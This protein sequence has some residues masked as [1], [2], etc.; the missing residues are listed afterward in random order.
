MKNRIH[1]LLFISLSLI[2]V[3]CSNDEK[4]PLQGKVQFA[5]SIATKSS[6]GGR[7]LTQSFPDGAYIALSIETASGASV[8]SLKRVELL[9]LNN[10]YITAPIDLTEGSYHLTDF[11]ILSKE[12]EALFATPKEGS[13]LAVFVVDPLPINF[14]IH[15]DGLVNLSVQVVDI[16]Q[17]LPGDFGYVSFGVEVVGSDFSISLFTTENN[18]LSFISGTLYLYQDDKV[19][20]TQDLS[21]KVNSVDFKGNP[22]ETYTLMVKK[23]GYTIRTR[24]YILKELVDELAGK[25]L[26]LTFEPAFT[27]VIKHHAVFDNN[28]PMTFNLEL[29]NEAGSASNLTVDWGDGTIDHFGDNGYPL[30]QFILHFYSDSLAGKQGVINITGDISNASFFILLNPLP[31]AI[32]NIDLSRFANLDA[33]YWDTSMVAKNDTPENIDVSMN[34]KLS[35]LIIA[36]S[37]IKYINISN[38]PLLTRVAISDTYISIENLNEV[39]MDLTERV[40]I[41]KYDFFYF[42]VSTNSVQQNLSLLTE[43]SR[44]KL[45]RLRDNYGWQINPNPE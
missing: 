15:S 2:V 40:G 30:N 10:A 4:I 35:T 41:Y 27:M 28:L 32:T 42:G 8:Y 31:L 18:K 22:D 13:D 39:I 33:F 3:N 29:A 45:I 23:Q 7:I 16:A 21:P 9:K 19:I 43:E 44:L 25:P 38:N 14:S 12:G 17:Q 26:V 1:T 20:Y 34:P 11:M 24:E 5:V 6:D 36:N 37:R